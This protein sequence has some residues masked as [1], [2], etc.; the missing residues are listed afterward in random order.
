MHNIR[1][2]LNVF[3]LP[4]AFTAAFAVFARFGCSDDAVPLAAIPGD[5]LLVTSS[6]DVFGASRRRPAGGRIG[7]DRDGS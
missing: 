5:R 6:D 7:P 1:S 3:C 2:K 4:A